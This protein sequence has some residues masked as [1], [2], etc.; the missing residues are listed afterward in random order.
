MFHDCTCFLS[1]DILSPHLSIYNKNMFNGS[2]LWSRLWDLRVD[3][4]GRSVIHT[5]DNNFE[6][7]LVIM[8]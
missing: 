3:N 4:S 7:V 2:V 1:F 6:T 5:F 8:L